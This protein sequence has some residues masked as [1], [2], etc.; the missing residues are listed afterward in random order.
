[1]TMPHEIAKENDDIERAN[2]AE[3][4]LA[5]PMINAALDA[6]RL[7]AESD[8]RNAKL[9]DIPAIQAAKIRHDM[10]EQF[11]SELQQHIRSGAIAADKR[12]KR[13]N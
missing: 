6:I 8:M 13:M 4:L 10:V 2:R 1:M 5:N 12:K 9:T 11:R 3:A 7:K